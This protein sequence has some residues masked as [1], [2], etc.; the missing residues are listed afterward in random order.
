VGAQITAVLCLVLDYHLGTDWI[1]DVG[2]LALWI[3]M[4]LAVYSG[5]QYIVNYWRKAG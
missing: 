3:A 5:M 2:M 1:T 4:V